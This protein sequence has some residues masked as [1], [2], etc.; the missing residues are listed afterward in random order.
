MLYYVPGVKTLTA[1]IRTEL[2][3]VIDHFTH[4]ETA[5]GPDGAG[6]VIADRDSVTPDDLRFNKERQ[7]WKR[8][9]GRQSWIGAYRDDAGDTPARYARADQFDG[10]PMRM[11]DGR[12]W[13]IPQLRVYRDSADRMIWDCKLPY[14][15]QQDPETG[16]M[17]RGECVA[18]YRDLF[19]RSCKIVEGLL[20]AGQLGKTEI[21]IADV[22]K[23]TSQVLNLNYRIQLPEL[24]MLKLCDS[25]LFAEVVWTA[26]DF[27]H[28]LDR[29]KNLKSR[30]PASGADSTSGK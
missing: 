24:S 27:H 21:Q 9:F 12:D 25:R 23:F 7:I 20:L 13:L 29:L 11:L 1:E 19:D 3:P 30:S 15:V 17:V 18:K 4:R 10:V 2:A 6:I 26:I 14:V 28:M 8:A 5:D 22:D 16:V